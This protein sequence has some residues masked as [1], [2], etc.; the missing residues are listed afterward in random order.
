MIAVARLHTNSLLAGAGGP[1]A[2]QIDPSALARVGVTGS[3][4]PSEQA[5]IRAESKSKAEPA[6]V[7]VRSICFA[8]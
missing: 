2:A 8:G 4:K 6:L 1:R 7:L 3:P 5:G